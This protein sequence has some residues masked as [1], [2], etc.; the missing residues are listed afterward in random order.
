MK[1][2]VGIPAYNEEKNITK[3][4]S[5]IKEITSSII[6]CDDHS[7]DDTNKIVKSLGVDVVTHS[8]NMGYGEAIKSIFAKAREIDSDVLVT[9]DADGQHRI[10]DL[11][12]IL[13][14]VLS[15][16]VDVSIGSR[17]LDD[18][19]ENVPSYRK[20]G[21]KVLTKLTNISLN[22][23][24]TDSQSGFRV[25]SKKAITKII[26]TESGMAIS[27]EILLKAA[28]NNLKIGEVPIVV[29]YDG[30][31]STHNPVSHGTSVFISTVKYIAI[32][33]PLQFFVLPGLLIL[34][35]GLSFVLWALQLFTDSGVLVTNIAL[36]GIACLIF[37]AIF[38]IN[39]INLFSITHLIREK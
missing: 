21:I 26:P 15:G 22:D 7:T 1:I 16:T 33:H 25:Y 10:E 4:I 3:I 20:F 29:L 18:T 12:K 5:Q 37:G 8:K 9:M 17:F 28:H 34:L 31:T 23:S 35:L 39:G 2:T 13:E 38:M 6:V 32:D 27:N 30:D 11:K 14:P 19:V 24:I 36:I